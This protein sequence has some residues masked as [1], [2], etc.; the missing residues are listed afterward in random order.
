MIY[1][2]VH[3]LV[4]LKN[5]QKFVKIWGDPIFISSYEIAKSDVIFRFVSVFLN[6]MNDRSQHIEDIFAVAILGKR[7]REVRVMPYF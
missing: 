1:N 4:C 6:C 2:M 5:F 3:F 7:P